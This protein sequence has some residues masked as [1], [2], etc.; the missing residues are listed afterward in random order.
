MGLACYTADKSK[1]L[2]RK[3][4]IEDY[5]KFKSIPAAVEITQFNNTITNQPLIQVRTYNK[6]GEYLEET[7]LTNVQYDLLKTSY[8]N[9]Y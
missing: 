1:Y 4:S 2:K 8:F 6:F 5:F 9:N 3:V 7:V